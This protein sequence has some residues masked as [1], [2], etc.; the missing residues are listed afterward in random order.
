MHLPFQKA[1]QA[2][3]RT[4]IWVERI[5]LSSALGHRFGVRQ[6]TY[7]RVLPLRQSSPLRVGALDSIDIIWSKKEI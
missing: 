2:R 1:L 3:P 6:S 4:S 5:E 7:R